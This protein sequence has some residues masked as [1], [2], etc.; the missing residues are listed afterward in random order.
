MNSLSIS[1]KWTALPVGLWQGGYDNYIAEVMADDSQMP[2][3]SK[4]PRKKASAALNLMRLSDS[5]NYNCKAH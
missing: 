5:L 2:C 3:A 4:K 1:A